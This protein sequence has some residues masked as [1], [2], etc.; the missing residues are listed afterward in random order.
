MVSTIPLPL[1]PNTRD[2]FEAK[3]DRTPGQGPEGDCHIWRGERDSDGYGIAYTG[4]KHPS[5]ASWQK[6][7]AH[8]LAIFLATGIWPPRLVCHTC[9]NP[10][11]VNTD[12]LFFGTNAD[13]VR[14]M[15][16]KGRRRNKQIHRKLTLDKAREIRSLI[17]VETQKELARRFGVS[18][19]T[20]R[21]VR[22]GQAWRERVD[23]EPREDVL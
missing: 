4:Y 16:R 20:I 14:D 11:C 19:K 10:P 2:R 21:A 3:V 8:R 7:R 22:N 5:G 1:K 15:D 23:P 18:T 12:H 9:D 17:G 6:V 13:N